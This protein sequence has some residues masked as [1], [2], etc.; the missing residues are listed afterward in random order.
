VE[1]DPWQQIT[2]DGNDTVLQS[3]W[4]SERGSPN[5]A[6]SEPQDPETRAAW[7]AAQHANTPAIA[8]LDTLGRTFLTIADNGT[9]GKYETCVEL[10]IEGNQ[11]SVTDALGRKVMTYDYDILG[12]KI[13]QIS[14]DAG[15]RWML[16]DVGGKPIRAWDSRDHQVRHEYDELHR[17]TRL[18][19][20]ASG[21]TVMLAERTVYGEPLSNDPA[22]D[23]AAKA[24]NLRGK[25]FQQFDGAGAITSNQ[26]DF[27]GNL[28][29]GS[30]Q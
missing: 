22:A 25:V 10:D 23:V 18:F 16:N 30:R 9:A 29:S 8:H 28:L 26:Y 12:T 19:V 20:Q 2:A 1:F 5:P 7:L 11:R 21:G 6:A 4:Y 24:A 17:P 3:K 13:H 15:E 27:K 14:M